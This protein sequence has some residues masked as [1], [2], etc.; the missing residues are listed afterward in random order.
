VTCFSVIGRSCGCQGINNIILKQAIQL[1][2]NKVL[3][4]KQN[5]KSQEYKKPKTINHKINIQLN[6]FALYL[7]I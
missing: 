2:I 4:F 6:K 5:N 3:D 1:N 7:L